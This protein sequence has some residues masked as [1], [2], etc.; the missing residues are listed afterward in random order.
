MQS[1]MEAAKDGFLDSLQSPQ[2]PHQQVLSKDMYEHAIYRLRWKPR[3]EGASQSR[4]SR[5][6]MERAHQ[7]RNRSENRSRA[8]YKTITILHIGRVNWSEDCATDL[9]R[10]HFDSLSPSDSQ[11]WAA[12]L[13]TLREPTDDHIHKVHLSSDCVRGSRACDWAVRKIVRTSR[14]TT[15]C[16]CSSGRSLC[17]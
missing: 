3:T 8:V 13:T 11:T 12:T 1:S 7:N 16:G 17:P 10:G 9:A 15:A 14:C 4:N 2:I 6:S 5:R